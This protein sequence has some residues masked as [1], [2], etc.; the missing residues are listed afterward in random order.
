MVREE[1]PAAGLVRVEEPLGI[2]KARNRA[3]Q[4]CSTNIVIT[5]DDDCVMPSAATVRQ[6]LTDFAHARIAAVAIPFH[7]PF[8]QLPPSATGG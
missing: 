8:H 2:I 7:N 1:F 3:M 5:I 4:L 6:T